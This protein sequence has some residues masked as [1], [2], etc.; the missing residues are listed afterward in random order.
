[1]RHFAALRAAR[2]EPDLAAFLEDEHTTGAP[3][4][5]PVRSFLPKSAELQMLRSSPCLQIVRGN[6]SVGTVVGAVK[7]VMRRDHLPNSIIG[8]S[9]RA[10]ATPGSY[11]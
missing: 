7:R 10:G 3:G 11:L 2:T 1:M 8:E 9:S 6:A 4:F 5:S